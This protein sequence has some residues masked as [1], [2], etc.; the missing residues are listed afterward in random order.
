MNKKITN[1]KVQDFLTSLGM[2]AFLLF[3]FA[4]SIYG[5]FYFF[6]KLARL[7]GGPK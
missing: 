3:I 7:V 2:Y 4:A 5:A 1:E 6:I